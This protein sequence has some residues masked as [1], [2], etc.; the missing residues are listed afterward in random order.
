[1][2][3]ITQGESTPVETLPFEEDILS[4][5]DFNNANNGMVII[6]CGD[7]VVSEANEEYPNGQEIFNIVRGQYVTDHNNVDFAGL[8]KGISDDIANQFR[9]YSFRGI[10]EEEEAF[11]FH[12]VFTVHGMQELGVD[13]LNPAVRELQ[14]SRK[15]N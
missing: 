4:F 13:Y 2:Q 6:T 3:I 7:I 10:T 15:L 8:L 5:A 11:F 12:H 14:V 1:M 9:V